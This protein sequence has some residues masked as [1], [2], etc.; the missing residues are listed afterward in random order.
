MHEKS[1]QVP[2]NV[3]FKPQEL[4]LRNPSH[5]KHR[6]FKPLSATPQSPWHLLGLA[7]TSSS[8]QCFHQT[9]Q[10]VPLHRSHLRFYLVAENQ[11]GRVSRMSMPSGLNGKDT[12]HLRNA[13]LGNSTSVF[14]VPNSVSRGLQSP[15][16]CGDVPSNSGGALQRGASSVSCR[17]P[18]DGDA[19]ARVVEAC[20]HIDCTCGA[21]RQNY[22]LIAD[23]Q[24][25]P[26][27][28]DPSFQDWRCWR[29]WEHATCNTGRHIPTIMQPSQI[30][31]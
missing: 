29:K 2:S 31:F 3:L 12:K 25:R 1:V 4:T 24:L 8:L 19:S 13:N 14:G 26:H 30:D 6:A 27:Y 23:M 21:Q 18:L 16:T 11:R 17:R 20:Q 10:S 22:D 5:R 28:G 9:E 7:S 15:Q